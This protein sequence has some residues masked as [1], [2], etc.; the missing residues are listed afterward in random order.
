MMSAEDW[1]GMRLGGGWSA[2]DFDYSDEEIDMAGRAPN[3]EA[4]VLGTYVAN[5][6]AVGVYPGLAPEHFTPGPY[7]AVYEHMQALGLKAPPDPIK[8]R[9]VCMEHDGGREAFLEILAHFAEPMAYLRANVNTL[10]ARKAAASMGEAGNE[11]GANARGFSVDRDDPY[12]L[13]EKAQATLDAAK[14]A[15]PEYVPVGI[16]EALEALDEDAQ[17][18]VNAPRG[19]VKLGIASIDR[20]IESVYPGELLVVAA[21]SG[22]GKTHLAVQASCI[23]AD[24]G[25]RVLFMSLEMSRKE[26]AARILAYTSRVNARE[27]LTDNLETEDRQRIEMARLALKRQMWSIQDKPGITPEEVS[28]VARQEAAKSALHLLVV[29]YAGLLRLPGKE[30]RAQ[31]LGQAVQGLKNLA[32]EL[33]CVVLLVAQ[34]N[35]QGA[36]GVPGLHHLKDSGDIEQAAD[37]VV[38]LYRETSTGDAYRRTK[39]EEQGPMHALLAKSRRA[40]TGLDVQLQ[41]DLGCSRM[42]EFESRSEDMGF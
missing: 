31:E 9:E 15:R 39:S 23:T 10:L 8:V 37:H 12:E 17:A 2:F 42:P 13:Q 41:V 21:R 36:D 11:I 5:P 16:H 25:G 1:T 33:N 34:I 4:A 29:D 3:R 35:R 38:M 28:V 22:V 20:R 30:T 14:S 19:V 40:G 6:E 18:T 26:V 7:R 27:L 32:R 24:R